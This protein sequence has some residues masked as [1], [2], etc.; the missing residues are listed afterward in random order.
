VPEPHRAES[1]GHAVD[2]TGVIV[3][4]VPGSGKDNSDVAIDVLEDALGHLDLIRIAGWQPECYTA[5]RSI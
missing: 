3:R 2:A 1:I 5:A 4:V